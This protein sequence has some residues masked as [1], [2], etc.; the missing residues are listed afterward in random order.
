M[1]KT[2]LATVMVESPLVSAHC[3]LTDHASRADR[4]EN[5]HA[6]H[7]KKNPGPEPSSRPN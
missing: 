7:D 1:K 2:L 4:H 3:S 6:A 5:I